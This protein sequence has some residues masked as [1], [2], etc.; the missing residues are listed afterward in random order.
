M[1]FGFKTGGPLTMLWGW[2]IVG[3]FT[4]VNGC[5]LAEICS[6]YPVSGSVYQWAGL[7]AKRKH[8]PFASYM[9]GWLN[10]MFTLASMVA[11]AFGVAKILV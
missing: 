4:I 6:T 11:I 9:A 7:L 2:V 10:F 8:A 3:I 1:S 5:V